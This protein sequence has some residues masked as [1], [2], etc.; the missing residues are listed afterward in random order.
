MC[1]GGGITTRKYVNSDWF[2]D[3]IFFGHMQLDLRPI[4]RRKEKIL[5]VF[6]SQNLSQTQDLRPINNS[7]C[8]KVQENCSHKIGCKI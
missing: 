3:R 8:N 7:Q 2:C 6:Q 1:V 4:W 5:S